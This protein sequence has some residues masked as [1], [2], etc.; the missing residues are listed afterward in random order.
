MKRF[1]AC[2]QAMGI[3]GVL[4]SSVA[5]G[6]PTREVIDGKYVFTVPA[7]E[8][9]TLT[10]D[11]VAAFDGYDLVKDGEGTLVAGVVV[12]N[13]TG[14]I[15]I[16]NG[17]YRAA[18]A[19]AL[20]PNGGSTYIFGA[21]TL[22]N[23]IE[24]ATSGKAPS[25]GAIEHFYLE[26]TGFHGMGVISNTA[27]CPD[28]AKYID[29]TGDV[30]IRSTQDFNFR[31]ATA[32]AHSHKLTT[33]TTRNTRF[34]LV[35]GASTFINDGDMDITGGLQFENT[36]SSGYAT[37]NVVIHDGG[38][39]CLRNN[40]VENKR[41]FVFGN[42]VRLWST[43]GSITPGKISTPNYLSGAVELQGTITNE[44]TR[45]Y[46]MTFG[47][48]VTGPGGFTGGSGGSLQF[49]CP[50][51]TFAGGVSLTGYLA[52][53]GSLTGGVYMAENGAIPSNGAPLKVKNA[54]VGTCCENAYS[55]TFNLPDLVA[56]GTVVV[57][58]RWVADATFKSL[59]KKGNGPI[60][61]FGPA[62]I[63]GTTDVQGGT[64]RF[65][66]RVPEVEPGLEWYSIPNYGHGNLTTFT[67]PTDVSYRG[68]DPA[69]ASMA[70][71]AWPKNDAETDSPMLRK[72]NYY[73]G[74]VRIPGEEGE[75]VTCSFISSICRYSRLRIG[76]TI[77]MDQR[78]NKNWIT[79]SGVKTDYNR[80]TVTGPFTF[81]AGWQRFELYMGTWHDSTGGAY[82]GKSP[83]TDWVANFGLGVDWQARCVTNSANYAKFLDP[84]DGSLLRA[85]LATDKTQKDPA[86][87]RPTFEGPV[88]FG[89]GTVFDVGDAAPYTPVTVPALT[90]APTVMN[91]EVHVTDTTWTLRAADVAAGQPLTVAAGAKVKFAA[92]TTIAVQDEDDIPHN[93]V[94]EYP[95]LRVEEGGTLE[96]AP[97]YARPRGSKWFAE[98]SADNTQ[99]NLAYHDGFCILI[100]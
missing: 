7:G 99:L 1:T 9:Y 3:V 75:D 95:I 59:T 32:N 86:N 53:D 26:G 2:V 88:A 20:G 33:R 64:L 90:G 37:N 72:D 47:G 6:A 74:Y 69:G 63:L 77:V 91:G 31:Y 23:Q 84:G 66:T 97:V 61:F 46:G 35:A 65:A 25:Y 42:A 67:P 50:S 54:I 58:N 80:L 22:H 81:K 98:W 79:G 73:F 30:F 19:G 11:D 36:T 14:D 100:R 8:T 28:F 12:T 78:D 83:K 94:K 76:G 44:M 17:I 89:P 85:T 71:K 5:V 21:G 68:V 70:Y 40:S 24:S 15:Y 10:A 52:K 45:P 51:N 82:L 38:F 93:T 62:R 57:T 16:T 29:F 13:Y 87:F 55:R 60:S 39:L 34:A 4:M 18:A 92:G 49:S 48:R 43:L 56:D 27:Y 41:H 96:N